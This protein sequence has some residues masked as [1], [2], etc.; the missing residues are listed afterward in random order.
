VAHGCLRMA[1]IRSGEPFQRLPWFSVLTA[2]APPG[3]QSRQAGPGPVSEAQR[4]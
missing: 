2:P 1:A 3:V 4:P